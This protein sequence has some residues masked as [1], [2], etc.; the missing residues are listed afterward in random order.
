MVLRQTARHGVAISGAA[1]LLVNVWLDR[2]ALALPV[3]IP[4]IVADLD[5][6]QGDLEAETC[7]FNGQVAV[8]ELGLAAA[9]AVQFHIGKSESDAVNSEQ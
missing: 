2:Q 1:P 9:L 5:H 4:E 8:V 6:R 7:R 3:A